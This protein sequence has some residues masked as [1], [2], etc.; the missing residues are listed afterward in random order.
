[1]T[2]SRSRIAEIVKAPTAKTR[3]TSICRACARMIATYC[4]MR[5]PFAKR[6]AWPAKDIMTKKVPAIA[7]RAT[8]LK[9]VLS[10]S[11]QARM[12]TIAT[13]CS[14]PARRNDHAK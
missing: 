13:N 3:A 6:P 1:M 7:V 10:N 11:I 14:N 2:P 12:P 8:L 5:P 4:R 9:R